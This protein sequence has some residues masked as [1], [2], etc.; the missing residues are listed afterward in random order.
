M[1]ASLARSGIGRLSRE[2]AGRC[3]SRLFQG[4]ATMNRH[5]RTRTALTVMTLATIVTASSG[6]IIATADRFVSLSEHPGAITR[7]ING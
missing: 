7:A 3:R 2:S 5:S 1:P 6:L 4:K